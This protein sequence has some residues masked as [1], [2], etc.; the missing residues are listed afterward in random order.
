MSDAPTK[1]RGGPDAEILS[2]IEKFSR[3]YADWRATRAA[4]YTH[5]YPNDDDKECDA[6]VEKYDA[7]EMAL[8]TTPAPMPWCVWLKWEALDRLVTNE[9]GSGLRGDVT[10]ALVTFALG[11]IKADLLRLGLKAP[12]W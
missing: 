7:A 10:F 11:A 6:R 12:E 9:G 1:C 5:D 8:L 2:K 3:A 4:M